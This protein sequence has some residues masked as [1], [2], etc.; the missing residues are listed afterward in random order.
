[1]IVGKSRRNRS[2]KIAMAPMK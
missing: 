1:M 2:M